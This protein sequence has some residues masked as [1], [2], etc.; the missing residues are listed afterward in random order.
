MSIQKFEDINFEDYSGSVEM[1]EFSDFEKGEVETDVEVSDYEIKDLREYRQQVIESSQPIIKKERLHMEGNNFVIAPVVDHFRGLQ[2]QAKREREERFQSEL[3][4]KFEEVREQAY[5]EGLEAGKKQG[6]EDIQN[7][8]QSVAVEKI[9]VLESY[10]QSIH[11][12]RAELLK[13]EKKNIYEIVKTLT[14][15]VILRELEDDGAYLERLLGK[16]ILEIQSKSNLLLKV[17]KEYLESMPEI[18]ELV[19]QRVGELTNTRVEPIARTNGE[20]EKGLILESENGI[21]DGTMNA[22]LENLENLFNEL[23]VYES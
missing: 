15:W 21:I 2:D 19:E 22:Q 14:K 11:D 16:L 6:Y 20:K 8:L 5:K 23:D 17:D 13:S 4:K 3:S 12:E 7:E 10:I 9:Q 18:F 1:Y